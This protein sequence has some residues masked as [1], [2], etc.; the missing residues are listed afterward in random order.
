MEPPPSE[1]PESS[2]PSREEVVELP[3]ERDTLGLDAPVAGCPCRATASRTAKPAAAVRV[4]ARF[5]ALA[6]LRPASTLVACGMSPFRPASL[7]QR[8]ER[9]KSPC[10]RL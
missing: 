2:S 10:R 7:R 6:R 1:E 9:A 5:A 4:T 8:C 3:V